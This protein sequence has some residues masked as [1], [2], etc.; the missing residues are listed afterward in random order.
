LSSIGIEA[1]LWSA[2]LV[3]HWSVFPVIPFFI[4]IFKA[5]ISFEYVDK[6]SFSSEKFPVGTF[7]KPLEKY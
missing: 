2:F 7:G 6:S 5:V 1:F 3:F 4:F